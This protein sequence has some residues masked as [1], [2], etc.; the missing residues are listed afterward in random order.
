[1]QEALKSWE[2]AIQKRQHAEAELSLCDPRDPVRAELLRLTREHN[3]FKD[4]YE[5]QLGALEY[6]TDHPA[7]FKGDDLDQRM[8]EE[9]EKRCLALAFDCEMVETASDDMALARVSAVNVKG[10]TVIDTL[11]LP[12]DPTFIV[13]CRTAITG[14]SKR[15]LIEKGVSLEEVRRQF[16]SVCCKD[17]IIMGHALD[18]DLLALQFKHDVVLDTSFLYPVL[19]ARLEKEE[20]RT[21]SLDHLTTRVLARAMDRAKRGGVHD[22]VEDAINSLDLVKYL[23]CAGKR[24]RRLNTI[25]RPWHAPPLPP[26]ARRFRERGTEFGVAGSMQGRQV[27]ASNSYAAR[28]SG[29]NE[30]EIE[31]AEDYFSV[32]LISSLDVHDPGRRDRLEAEEK[33]KKRKKEE[34][35]KAKLATT[36]SSSSLMMI[37]P[38][39]ARQSH[40]YKTNS[41]LVQI[42]N[43]NSVA[44][45]RVGKMKSKASLF[46]RKS[47]RVFK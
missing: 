13:D 22:S 33:E 3:L 32:H 36:S 5:D 27:F 44:N 40:A 11:V 25:E 4:K 43:R 23:V 47:S 7:A 38:G 31:F 20:E 18:H 12:C 15:E 10:E 30:T 34:E 9:Q 42:L 26:R 29:K 41:R 46:A 37:T 16:A 8:I 14:L 28:I 6:V 19:D 2:L 35:R 21:H 39:T 45:K 24:I 17:T 1:V